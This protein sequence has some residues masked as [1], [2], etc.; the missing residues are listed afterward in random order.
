[1]PLT[2]WSTTS[3]TLDFLALAARM[4]ATIRTSAFI[5]I[6]I[7][8]FIYVSPRGL[9]DSTFVVAGALVIVLLADGLVLAWKS[10]SRSRLVT[11]GRRVLTFAI[12]TMVVAVYLAPLDSPGVLVVPFALG[13][14][15]TLL[16]E[17][18]L[19]VRNAP[20]ING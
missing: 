19:R 8:A 16:L 6:L 18:P 5:A 7:V 3:D 9:V 2:S 12:T 13:A 20:V 11:W 1:M 4:T 15:A 17:V 10:P 14:I